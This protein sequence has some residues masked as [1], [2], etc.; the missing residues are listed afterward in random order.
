MEN[1]HSARIMSVL[2]QATEAIT[3]EEIVEQLSKLNKQI[4]AGGGKGFYVPSREVVRNT[5]NRLRDRG[6][7]I[8]EKSQFGNAQMYGRP[9]LMQ[10]PGKQELPTLSPEEQEAIIKETMT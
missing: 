7:V 5:L 10:N 4:V 1:S 9:E 2:R 3:V 6:D 8:S